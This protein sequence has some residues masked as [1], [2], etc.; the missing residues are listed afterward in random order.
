[1]EVGDISRFVCAQTLQPGIDPA[2]LGRDAGAA[3]QA[4]TSQT[5]AAPKVYREPP[6][7]AAVFARPSHLRSAA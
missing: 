7:P 2:T 6:L 1:M 5:E 3:L 4:E